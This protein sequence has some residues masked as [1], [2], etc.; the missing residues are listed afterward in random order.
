MI[1]KFKKNKKG[2]S[3][4][5]LAVSLGII[6]IAMVIFFN[7]L[8]VAMRTSLRNAVRSSMREELSI[9]AELISKDFRNADLVLDANCNG[10]TCSMRQGNTVV[11]WHLCSGR[12]CRR[13]AVGGGAENLVFETSADLNITTFTIERGFIESSTPTQNNLLITIIASQSNSTFNINNLI[14]QFTMSTRNYEY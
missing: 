9:V 1:N 11:R 7:S 10:N 3:L 2:Y 12:V 6:A 13:I 4:V 14:K 5:E 8:V